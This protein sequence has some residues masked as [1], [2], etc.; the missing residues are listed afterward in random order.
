[1]GGSQPADV[2]R[3]SI[4]VAYFSMEIALGDSMPTYSGGLGVLAG[5]TLRAAADLDVPIVGLTLV[6]R[7]GYFRQRLD[8]WGN[9]IEQ[10]DPWNPEQVL[11][12]VEPR[13][14]IEIEGRRIAVR[15]WRFGIAG[16]SRRRVNVYL[17]DTN[18]PENAE[19]DR[20]LT[21]HLY[22]G[23][24]RYR[25]CQEAILGLGGIALLDRLGYTG[26]SSYHMNEGHAALLA[27]ALLEKESGSELSTVS[28]DDIQT[29][30]KRCVF[31]THTPVPAGHDQFSTDLARAVLGEKVIRLLEA[32][33]CCP[34]GVMN[35][36]YIALRFS[37]YING[38]GMQHGEISRDMFPNFP[39]RAITN[40][41][42]A[43]TWIS[44]PF[45]RLF[46]THIPEW[47]SDNLYLRY[48]IGI[49]LPEIEGA[50]AEAKRRLIAEIRDRA[51]VELSEPTMTIGFARRA[52]PYKRPDLVLWNL[53]RLRWI[54]E[55]AG[56]LQVVFAGKAHPRDESGK[57]LIRKILDAAHRTNDTFKI[58]YLEDYDA[59]LARCLT[60]GV[61][62]W[63]NTPQR[64]NEASGTS[65]MK[66]ALNGV[67]SLSILDGW[68]VEGCLEGL[69]GW[70]IGRN[71]GAIDNAD[72]DAASLYDKLERIILPMFYGQ[73]KAY[74]EVMRMSIAVNGSFFNTQRMLSQYVANAYRL[75][76]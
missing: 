19:E 60:S 21:D 6:H 46:D 29:V 67:P 72:G 66:A 17:L 61:D 5:D 10:E 75:H 73:P 35:M 70:A 34:K 53:D 25:L 49:A 59:G 18:L 50:H 58:V 20:R 32:T 15:A 27:L 64:P 76:S 8:A 62:L 40:G 57:A 2:G 43:A 24:D 63:L 54:T 68:W 31:T 71:E 56:P 47:R 44:E 36:T 45:R 22:G 65:G 9:Q 41:V 51:G 12:P 3:V 33:G 14:E 11:D 28:E 39:V 1:M 4:R 7:K 37:R 13:V 38:V 26:I 52:T 42:H 69:T 30:R 48:A 23:D 74:A 55:H 16:T